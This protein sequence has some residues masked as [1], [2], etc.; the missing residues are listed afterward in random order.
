MRG[1][2]MGIAGSAVFTA[3]L[4]GVSS[5][6][7]AAAGQ[8]VPTVTPLATTVTYSTDGT[9]GKVVQTYYVGYTVSF[10]NPGKNT[11]ND[12]SFRGTISVDSPTEIA[13][14]SSAEGWTC[15]V[16]PPTTTGNAVTVSCPLGTFTKGQAKGPF[17]IFFKS[18]VAAVPTP[19][20]GTDKV[21][22]S[23]LIVQQEG[24][25]GPN[26]W[27]NSL[28]S[29]SAADVTLGT[30]TPNNVT[31]AVPKAGGTVVTND[32]LN[33]STIAPITT[34][35]TIPPISSY[36]TANLLQAPVTPCGSNIFSQCQSS[37]LTIPGTFDYLTIVLRQDAST[38]APTYTIPSIGNVFVQYTDDA[39]NVTFPVQPCSNPTTP[40]PGGIPCIASTNSTVTSSN[41]SPVCTD[42]WV[43]VCR[44]DDRYRYS[45]SSSYHDDDDC[46]YEKV[47]VCTPVY[48][49]LS[50]YFEWVIINT[51]N[52]KFDLF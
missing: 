27:N 38:F 3:A 22:F 51:K 37:T 15:S 29:W 42:K 39:G 33:P 17:A 20:A 12:V 4:L 14:F 23:G 46:H 31:T 11:I 6:A 48:L 41:T 52:G 43:K 7:M 16:Q 25:N 40:L 19:G 50:G 10:T 49:N 2:K 35:V 26:S 32:G 13:A 21:H 36:T 44:D 28:Y 18:P 45:S 9:G 30:T 5:G 47:T 34:K 1:I 8:V 24:F